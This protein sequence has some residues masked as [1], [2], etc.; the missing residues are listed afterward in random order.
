MRYLLSRVCTHA[1]CGCYRVLLCSVELLIDWIVVPCFVS[2]VSRTSR[3][4]PLPLVVSNDIT[5]VLELNG[6][7][8][9]MEVD[10]GAA[11]SLMAKNT[12]R[13]LFPEAV[14]E[15]SQVWLSTYSAEALRVVGAMK[16]QVHY[17]SYV[18]QHLLYVVSGDGPTLLG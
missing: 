8:V 17:D 12:Q 1:Q 3:S 16:V 6:Q 14:L 13:K 18:G 11:V 4:T 5:A 2:V 9:P 10:T 15:P 7:S